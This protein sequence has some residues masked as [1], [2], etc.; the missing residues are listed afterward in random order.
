[1]L[2]VGVSFGGPVD[3]ENGIAKRSYHV[4]GWDAFPLREYLQNEFN[5]PVFIDNDANLGALG[6]WYFGAGEKCSS[7]LYITVSTGIGAGWIIDGKLYRGANNM[8]GE[9][10][11]IAIDAT[12]P[13]CGCGKTG[14]LEALASGP[15]IARQAIRRLKATPNAE[16]KLRKL[17]R[18]NL[19]QITAEMVSQAANDD[20]NIAQE[21]LLEAATYLG[22]GIGQAITLINPERVILGGGVTKSGEAY[23]AAVRLAASQN[24]PP[25]IHV[26]IL[27]AQF[28]DEAPLWGAIA[29]A[30]QHLSTPNFS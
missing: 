20:D 4:A 3:F 13:K 6:E 15:A 23:W 21:V 10:G 28:T 17:C 27:P 22:M 5:V 26:N 24:V 29:L 30:T 14:C 12:G 11:H 1:L 18:N 16:S 7:L 25:C 2:V 8:A 19:E 9:I